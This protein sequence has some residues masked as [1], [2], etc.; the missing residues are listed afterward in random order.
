MN[1]SSKQIRSLQQTVSAGLRVL[2][3]AVPVCAVEWANENYY[4]PKE[5]SYQEGRWETLP[6]QVAIMNAMGS[7]DT[8]VAASPLQLWD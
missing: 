1:I 5:S 7:D 2:F 8:P 4:L 3:R 6:F